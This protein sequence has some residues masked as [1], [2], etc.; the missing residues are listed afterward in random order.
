MCSAFGLF[1][2]PHDSRRQ[3]DIV[4][5]MSA[6]IFPQTVIRMSQEF[7]ACYESCTPVASLFASQHLWLLCH[8]MLAHYFLGAGSSHGRLTRGIFGRLAVRQ[9]ICSRNTAVSLFYYAIERGALTPLLGLADIRLEEAV[10]SPVMLSL[11]I[12]WYRTHFEAMD[13]IDGGDRTKWLLADPVQRL[14][15]IQFDVACALL[16]QRTA[17]APGSP[18]TIF[19]WVD[20]DSLLL[21]HLIGGVDPATIG[22][23][24]R[25]VTTVTSLTS[26]AHSAGIS[27]AHTSRKVSAAE[28]L[29]GIGWTGR[30]GFSELWVSQSFFEEYARLQARKMLILDHACAR[31]R[32]G[33]QHPPYRHQMNGTR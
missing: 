19:N 10:P 1:Y 15:L 24:D 30:R 2:P 29:G 22:K 11:L 21:D 33:E 12:A 4:D 7:V 31:A 26:L 32:L 25:H 3:R 9:N 13:V 17:R 28:R 23:R 8:A 27:R 20:S 6:E 5:Y 16:C 18:S 14:A